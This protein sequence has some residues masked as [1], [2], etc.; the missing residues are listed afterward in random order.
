MSAVLGCAEQCLGGF[1]VKKIRAKNLVFT[2]GMV[3]LLSLLSACAG[4]HAAVQPEPA[5]PRLDFNRPIPADHP[6]HLAKAKVMQRAV[7]S[8]FHQLRLSF[9]DTPRY[10]PYLGVEDTLQEPVMMALNAEDYALCLQH[11]EKLL[12]YNYAS[13]AGHFAAMRCHEG[14]GAAEDA[15]FHRWVLSGLLDDVQSRGDGSEPAQAYITYSIN[16]LH[17]V[18]ALFGLEAKSQAVIHDESGAYDHMTVVQQGSE[19][20]LGIFF[21]ISVQMSKGLSWLNEE[22]DEAGEREQ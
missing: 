1:S 7:D 14:I 19:D 20:E 21:D 6:Y 5:T 4:Q 3:L 12:D 11:L 10:A 16:E 8:D 2:L 22:S 18:L 15:A 13:I 9:T 17:W